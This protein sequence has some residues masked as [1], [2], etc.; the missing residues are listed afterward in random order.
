MSEHSKFVLQQQFEASFCNM[1]PVA[2]SSNQPEHSLSSSEVPSCP[3]APP[4]STPKDPPRKGLSLYSACNDAPSANNTVA[5]PVAAGQNFD[6]KT[7]LQT[8]LTADAASAA[9]PCIQFG[10]SR[11]T[12]NHARCAMAFQASQCGT[13]DIVLSL[14]AN[15]SH[16]QAELFNCCMCFRL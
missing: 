10:V 14:Y 12:Q 2:S 4:R 9:Q 3:A 8:S 7:G 13:V 6:T 5:P 15:T 1:P 16:Q 11:R